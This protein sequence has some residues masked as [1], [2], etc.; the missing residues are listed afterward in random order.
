MQMIM[1]GFFLNMSWACDSMSLLPK[2]AMD[3]SFAEVYLALWSLLDAQ[4]RQVYHHIRLSLQS[5]SSSIE[6]YPHLC[7]KPGSRGREWNEERL[8]NSRLALC[9]N[10]SWILFRSFETEIANQLSPS[11]SN[12]RFRIVIDVLTLPCLFQCGRRLPALDL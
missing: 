6:L 11:F 7:W 2:T 4:S 12:C 8:M 5:S 3:L 9:A 1:S 10:R